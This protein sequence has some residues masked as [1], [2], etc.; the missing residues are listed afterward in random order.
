MNSALGPVEYGGKGL[1]W[2]RQRRNRRPL[3]SSQ[4]TKHT[5]SGFSPDCASYSKSTAHISANGKASATVLFVA[6]PP[7]AA[8]GTA[9]ASSALAGTDSPASWH[10]N[11]GVGLLL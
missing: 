2:S 7:P 6:Q 8:D 1:N 10:W 11:V 9:S 3:R 5:G 4:A